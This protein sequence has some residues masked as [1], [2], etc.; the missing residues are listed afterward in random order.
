M[1]LSEPNETGEENV[2]DMSVFGATPCAPEAGDDE[3]TEIGRTCGTPVVVVDP[4]SAALAP[5][6]LPKA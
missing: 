4:L 3:R 5:E 2:M 1:G 6:D